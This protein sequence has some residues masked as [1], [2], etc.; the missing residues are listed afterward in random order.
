[1]INNGSTPP[2]PGNVIDHE[3]YQED[4]VYVR[5]VGCP[6]GWP[7]G[8]GSDPC[9]SPGGATEVEAASGARVYNLWAYDS[10]TITMSGGRVQDALAGDGSSTVTM[11]GGEVEFLIA[12]ESATITLSGGEVFSDLA[13]TGSSTVTM[14]GGR[15]GE[16]GAGLLAYD[17]STITVSGGDLR[18]DLYAFDSSLIE[19]LGSGF[20][21][22]GVPVPYGDLTALTGRLTGTLALGDLLSADFYQ[23]GGNVAGTIRLVPEPTTALLLAIGLTGLAAA[24]RRRPHP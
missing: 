12:S 3:T 10:S 23:G 24:G 13:S 16:S 2:N 18:E 15:V 6:P 22:D 17:S 1:M 9:P 7:A 21:V 11:S 8:S 14:I 4:I 5:N 20:E 19:I